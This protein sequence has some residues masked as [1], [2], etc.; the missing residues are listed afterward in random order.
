MTDEYFTLVFKGSLREF[1]K[2]PLKTKTPFGIPWAAG[3]GD[4]FAQIDRLLEE[5]DDCARSSTG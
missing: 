2:N 1:E 4:A 5:I 3:V